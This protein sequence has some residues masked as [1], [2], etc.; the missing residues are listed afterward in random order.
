MKKWKEIWIY[1]IL[2]SRNYVLTEVFVHNKVADVSEAVRQYA[3]ALMLS[4]ESAIGSYG[5]KALSVLRLASNR[6]ESWNREEHRQSLP[7][8]R[9]LGVSLSERIAEQ[10]C[11][12]AAE[13]GQFLLP[14]RYTFVKNMEPPHLTLSNPVLDS[15]L[16][17][18]L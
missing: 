16:F 1:G 12:C 15:F 17:L 11:N 3:D 18:E 5:Q 8:K 7:N 13:M 10:I 14:R 6:M 4:G 2:E 9:Q